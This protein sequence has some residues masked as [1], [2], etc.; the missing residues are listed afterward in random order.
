MKEIIQRIKPGSRI[1]LFLDYDGTLVPIK[2]APEFAVFHPL[3][4]RLLKRL[5]EK[6]FICIVSGRSPADVR[7]L[8]G[9][10]GIAYIGNHG[11]EIC[12]GQRVWVHPEA[13]KI[14]PILN[15]ALK[16]IQDRTR[17]FTG[18][19]IENKGVTG[20]IHYRLSAPALWNPLKETIR[21]EAAARHRELKMTEGKR[22]FEIRPNVDWNKGKGICELLSR[23]DLDKMP[24][25]IYI[26]DDQT[27][28][29]AFRVLAK[30]D[31]T[32]LVGR[33]KD[34][35][36]RYRLADVGQVWRFLKNLLDLV[37]APE[38]T[39]FAKRRRK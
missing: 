22:V 4:R 10:R 16:N 34:S 3:R 28:E 14:R 5:S 30:D 20:S 8:V 36:A 25:R 32:I 19:R 17:D 9:L 23:L 18:V 11:L 13:E 37:S 31:A 39:T 27:D 26:G 6:V 7:K 21:Q 15:N 35:Q 33:R 38:T 29:D 12:F 1:L 2:K 24:L